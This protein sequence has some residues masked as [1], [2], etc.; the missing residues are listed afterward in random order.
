MVPSVE[1]ATRA[2]DPFFC[3]HENALS[4]VIAILAYFGR[5]LES[6]VGLRRS[7]DAQ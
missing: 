4:E 3:T 7:R 5:L 1:L 6:M 2:H